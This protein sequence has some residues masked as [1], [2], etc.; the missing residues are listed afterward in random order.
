MRVRIEDSAG[1]VL[2]TFDTANDGEA[3]TTY[4]LD[5]SGD[6]VYV[7]QTL[8]GSLETAP[9]AYHVGP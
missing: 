3:Y 2:A 9:Q 1:A 6:R 8:D 7:V 4:P 5:F